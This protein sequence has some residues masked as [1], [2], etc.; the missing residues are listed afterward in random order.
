VPDTVNEEVLY[1]VE[2]FPRKGR[3]RSDVPGAVALLAGIALLTGL[4]QAE[5][6]QRLWAVLLGLTGVV[7]LSAWLALQARRSLAHRLVV[8]QQGSRLSL[9]LE[10]RG[11]ALRLEGP[12]SVSFG[13]TSEWVEAAVVARQVPVLWVRV[14]A[15]G[16]A[17]TVRR[18]QGVFDRIPRDWPCQAVPL[19]APLYSSLALDPMRLLEALR[20][21]LRA[22]VTLRLQPG[23]GAQNPP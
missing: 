10:H 2:V 9:S 18:A 17:L 19:E 16:G 6:R 21:D 5:L 15:P 12:L 7:A 11:R 23:T 3:W 20:V 14:Q 1:E 22:P 8:A 13:R 4:F